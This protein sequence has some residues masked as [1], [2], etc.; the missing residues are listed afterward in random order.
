MWLM[1]FWPL[2]WT[3]CSIWEKMWKQWKKK[4]LKVVCKSNIGRRGRVYEIE[5]EAIA[6]NCIDTININSIRYYSK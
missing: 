6:K 3:V 4:S 1:C 5:Q 2:T